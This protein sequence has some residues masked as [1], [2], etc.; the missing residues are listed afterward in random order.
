MALSL[1]KAEYEANV[2]KMNEQSLLGRFFD[3]EGADELKSQAEKITF[4]SAL[5]A[6]I[7]RLSKDLDFDD[8]TKNKFSPS[9]L[10]ASVTSMNSI[11]GPLVGAVYTFRN[12]SSDAE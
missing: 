11:V 1:Q 5:I 9:V 10:A 6:R 8:D 7:E 2:A 4:Y 3:V 12:E